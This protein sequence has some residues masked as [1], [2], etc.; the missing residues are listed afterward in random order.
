MK[1]LGNGRMACEQWD[2]DKSY[3]DFVVK[4]GMESVA[5][6]LEKVKDVLGH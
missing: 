5:E 6:E 4:M 2:K 3:G 1:N